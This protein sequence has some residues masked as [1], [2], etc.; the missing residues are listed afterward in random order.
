MKS[1]FPLVANGAKNLIEYITKEIKEKPSR[2]FAARDFTTRYTCDVISSCLYGVDAQSF[3]SESPQMFVYAKKFLKGIMNSLV[4]NWPS[5]ML[6]DDVT[7]FFM[8]L[9]KQSIALRLKNNIDQDDFLAQMIALQQSKGL[10]DI[11]VAAH[12]LTI[13]LNSFETSAITFQNALYELARN[14]TT[15]RKL[16]QEIKESLAANKSLTYDRINELPYLDQV[17]YETLRMHPPLTFIT[18]VCSEDIEVDGSTGDK[19]LIKK[20]SAIWIPIHSIHRDPGKLFSLSNSTLARLLFQNPT[21]Y[22][23]DPNRFHPERFDSEYGGVKAFKER[24]VLIPFGDGPRICSGMKFAHI[25]VKTA[26]SE[27]IR[28]FEVVVDERSPDDF[29][30]S[31]NEFMNLPDKEVLFKFA[32]V[33]L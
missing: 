25:E 15:Q 28:N 7:K 16:R 30:I 29:R 21:E 32:E 1:V 12:C 5:K 11:D 23:H 19:V 4:A 9:T 20:D 31:P 24:C 33:K 17:F 22:Y 10:K 2:I 14:Q 26:I 8:N 13:Y 18:R 3:S 6:T 27:V